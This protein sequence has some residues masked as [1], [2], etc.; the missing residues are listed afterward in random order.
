MM[1]ILIK[2][3]FQ[4]NEI[5]K[6]CKLAAKTLDFIEPYVK[7]GISTEELDKLIFEFIKSHDATPAPLGYKGFPKSTC[8]SINEVVCHGIPSPNDILKEGDIINIDITTILNNYYGDTS[9]MFA[10]GKISE[11]AQNLINTAKQCLDQ[12][13]EVVK[14]NAKFKTI[15]EVITSLAE[16][17]NYSVV[18]Q[19]VGHGVG[20]HFHEPPH[21]HHN[22][23]NTHTSEPMKP[24]MIFTIE[25]MINSG[26]ETVFIDQTDYWT[27][28]TADNS[29]S[30]QFE[31][32]ILV[33][34]KGYEILTIN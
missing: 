13:I 26:K 28:K 34:E 22:V 30:A 4:I 5:R 1:K 14:P 6:S 11:E 18:S 9:R 32:T 15:A 29:L 33:T 20:I 21:V 8:T 25:P 10:V 27:V 2:N 31:H 3:K 24:G 23:R 16:N 7:P 17:Q 12:A 19:F